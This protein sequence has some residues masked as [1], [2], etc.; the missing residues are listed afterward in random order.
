M[1][2]IENQR[3]EQKDKHSLQQPRQQP[4]NE[5]HFNQNPRYFRQPNNTTAS[6]FMPLAGHSLAYS[7]LRRS[8]AAKQMAAGD[9]A[10]AEK[11]M[12]G[13][14]PYTSSGLGLNQGVPPYQMS[15]KDAINVYGEEGNGESIAVL[16]VEEMAGGFTNT[17]ILQTGPRKHSRIVD[18]AMQLE[19]TK[20]TVVE[21]ID[22]ALEK[23]KSKRLEGKASETSF[24][25]T[26]NSISPSRMKEMKSSCF[27]KIEDEL[28]FLKTLDRFSNDSE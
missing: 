6:G 2:A 28:K 9:A 1:Y 24:T 18:E 8:N 15:S 10:R 17:K 3:F 11:D 26:E 23:L 12:T 20:S 7:E 19:I 4:I 14:Q 21:L 25:G 5:N 22:N 16:N 13:Y 27:K